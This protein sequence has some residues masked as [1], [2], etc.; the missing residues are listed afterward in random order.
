MSPT[1]ETNAAPQPDRDPG[2]VKDPVC[3]MAVDPQ[4]AK[5]QHT[6]Q[7]RIYY[8]CSARCGEKFAASPDR[9][10]TPPALVPENANFSIAVSVSG[11][12]DLYLP[13]APGCESSQTR[14]LS[15]LWHGFGAGRDQP[16]Y[17]TIAGTR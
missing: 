15:A 5:H 9:Y 16:G 2:R 12:R 10:M 4:T 1:P 7:S 11:K 6:F 3:G 17:R 14:P 8:F 13:D